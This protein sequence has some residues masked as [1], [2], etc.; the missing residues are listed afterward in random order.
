[1]LGWVQG[2][3]CDPAD[4][5]R[6]FRLRATRVLNAHGCVRFRHWRLYGERGLAGARAAVWVWDETLT[7]EHAAET[8]AQYR[9]A[10]EADG[11]RLREVADPRFF[12]T[13]HVSPQ[14]FLAPLQE[15]AWHPAQRVT[16]YRP[17]RQ[18]VAAEQ[19]APLPEPDRE[20]ASG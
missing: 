19:Q 12:P 6:L 9:V 2:A 14:P 1:M 17:R 20:T 15:T 13:S 3:W 5:D 10:V 18:C 11:R 8:L 16:P 7:I 4:L